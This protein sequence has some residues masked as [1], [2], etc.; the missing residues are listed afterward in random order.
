MYNALETVTMD[1]H[2]Q[3][4]E[5]SWIDP[6]QTPF[7]LALKDANRRICEPC[8]NGGA[9]GCILSNPGVRC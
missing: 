9:C 3:P 1:D 8:R 5:G 4:I 2:G 6:S 7:A